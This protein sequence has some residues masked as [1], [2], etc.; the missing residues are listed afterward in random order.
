MA[1][2]KKKQKRL[3]RL[4]VQL[5]GRFIS[6]IDQIKDAERRKSRA[7]VV[8]LLLD[9]ALEYR[10]THKTISW[11]NSSKRSY[12]SGIKVKNNTAST[13]LILAS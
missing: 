4:N 5:D 8:E 10:N 12:A 13:L 3:E 9:E 7:N 11:S 2:T 6:L 1:K